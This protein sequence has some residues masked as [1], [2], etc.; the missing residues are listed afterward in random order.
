MHRLRWC[1]TYTCLKYRAIKKTHVSI[2]LWYS[3]KCQQHIFYCS[4][5]KVTRIKNQLEWINKPDTRDD[6][7]NKKCCEFTLEKISQPKERKGKYAKYDDSKQTGKSQVIYL[8]Y[9]II[10]AYTA[11]RQ[12]EYN[13]GLVCASIELTYFINISIDCCV[14]CHLL[15]S[16]HTIH[17][18]IANGNSIK[19]YWKLCR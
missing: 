4:W 10:I 1:T 5:G 11:F 7:H 8:V 12:H 19:V 9:Q 13:I 15:H 18:S 2:L 3:E 6:T 17:V 14:V 16:I